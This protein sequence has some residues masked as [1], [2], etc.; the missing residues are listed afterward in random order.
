LARLEYWDRLSHPV[1]VGL[2]GSA[3]GNRCAV[4]H[5]VWLRILAGIMNALRD[6]HC[7]IWECSR[8]QSSGCDC[9]HI[10]N[11][12]RVNS[13]EPPCAASDR[14]CQRRCCNLARKNFWRTDSSPGDFN[15]ETPER[16]DDRYMNAGP[17]RR[18]RSP[19]QLFGQADITTWCHVQQTLFVTFGQ[20][21]RFNEYAH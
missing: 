21:Q 9:Q 4:G 10:H 7:S 19:G 5:F 13:M 14:L 17:T 11:G 20:G 16:I 12:Y 8:Q 15:W 1:L 18:L 2:G 6:V 3:I